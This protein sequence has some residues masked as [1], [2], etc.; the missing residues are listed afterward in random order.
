MKITEATNYKE[1]VI[2]LLKTEKLVVSDLS[3]EL[4]NFIVALQNEEVIGVAGLEIYGDYGFLRSVAVKQDSRNK[5]IAGELVKQIEKQAA[6]TGLEEIYLLT[7]TASEYFKR[8]AYVQIART[9]VPAEVQRSSEFSY[10][11]PQS[12]IVMMKTLTD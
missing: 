4:E 5:G 8:K 3:A 7:E 9:D 1:S 11:C 2:N 6:T 10:A 12:A